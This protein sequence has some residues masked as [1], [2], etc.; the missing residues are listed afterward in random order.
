VDLDFLF[1]AGANVQTNEEVAI[2]LVSCTL[3]VSL[4]T[5]S[6][7]TVLDVRFVSTCATDHCSC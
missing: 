3:C 2:K 5:Q 6:L 1:P 4:P 7:I